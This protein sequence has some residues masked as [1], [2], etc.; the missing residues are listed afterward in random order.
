[1]LGV[2]G[3]DVR[4]ATGRTHVQKGLADAEN[5]GAGSVETRLANQMGIVCSGGW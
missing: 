3:T 4:N 2:G 5:A 1:M